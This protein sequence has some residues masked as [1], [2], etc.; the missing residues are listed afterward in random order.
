MALLRWEEGVRIKQEFRSSEMCGGRGRVNHNFGGW[1]KLV[2][3]GIFQ[4]LWNE[5]QEN[6]SVWTNLLVLWPN[7]VGV[8]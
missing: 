2:W 6:K 8:A 7:S 1:Q 4:L 3:S 5:G